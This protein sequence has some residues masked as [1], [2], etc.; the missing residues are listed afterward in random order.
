MDALNAQTGP[1]F[2]A[3]RAEKVIDDTVAQVQKKS[4]FIHLIRQTELV[5][6]CGK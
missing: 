3:Y 5:T 2:L 1:I 6:R 4:L